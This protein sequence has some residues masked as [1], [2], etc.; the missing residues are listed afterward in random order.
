MTMVNNVK[1][2][3]FF[4]RRALEAI[5]DAVVIWQTK[6]NKRL[7]LAIPTNEH[8]R[9]NERKILRNV[10]VVA[11]RMFFSL[12]IPFAIPRL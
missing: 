5:L 2:M 3:A 8:L 4:L 1:P 9:Y 6:A 12:T 7:I 10:R 11:N